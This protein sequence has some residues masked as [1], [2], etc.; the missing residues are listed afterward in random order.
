M[1]KV[2]SQTS[3]GASDGG[4]VR[5]TVPECV[6]LTEI[7]RRQIIQCPSCILRNTSHSTST[8]APGAPVPYDSWFSPG[9]SV[10]CMYSSSM[11]KVYNYTMA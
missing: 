7:R 1:F 6:I 4:S 2:G 10:Y 5:R 8:T 11:V 9:D 3:G